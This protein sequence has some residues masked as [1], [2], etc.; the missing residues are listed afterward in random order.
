MLLYVYCIAEIFYKICIYIYLE[1]CSLE[2][3]SLKIIWARFMEEKDVILK[4]KYIW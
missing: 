3:N 2:S 1:S 4:K